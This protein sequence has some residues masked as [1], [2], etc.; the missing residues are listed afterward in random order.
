MGAALGYTGQGGTNFLRLIKQKTMSEY[1]GPELAQKIED[2]IK[3]QR[4]RVDPDNQSMPTIHGYDV[5]ILV[6]AWEC[7]R[8][9]RIEAL[10]GNAN[11]RVKEPCQQAGLW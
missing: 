8:A 11:A 9:K 6:D 4:A 5:T 10:Q 7:T 2:P 3:F 1:V